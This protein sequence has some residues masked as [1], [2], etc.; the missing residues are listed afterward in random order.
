MVYRPRLGGA[1]SSYLLHRSQCARVVERGLV[2]PDLPQALQVAAVAALEEAQEGRVLLLELPLQVV[3]DDLV[4]L[5][6]ET[7]GQRG[8]TL[9]HDLLLAEGCLGQFLQLQPARQVEPVRLR[10]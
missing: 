5:I 9:A 4:Q 7:P 2:T 6:G 3:G 10:P 1:D 8:A